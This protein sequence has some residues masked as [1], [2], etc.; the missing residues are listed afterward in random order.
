MTNKIAL[1]YLKELEKVDMSYTNIYN[2]HHELVF[3]TSDLIYIDYHKATTGSKYYYFASSTKQDNE[4][5]AIVVRV[6]DHLTWDLDINNTAKKIN[7]KIV[8]YEATTDSDVTEAV[9]FL[10]SDSTTIT[11]KNILHLL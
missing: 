5:L 8:T 10:E 2:D 1:A 4:Y 11:L 6:S 9:R 7:G 3:S